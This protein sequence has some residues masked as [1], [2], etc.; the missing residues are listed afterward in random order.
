[1]PDADQHARERAITALLG[2]IALCDLAIPIDNHAR[3]EWVLA[4]LHLRAA[5]AAQTLF[6]SSIDGYVDGHPPAKPTARATHR[7]RCA[8]ALVR[9][10]ALHLSDVAPVAAAL[11]EVWGE[12]DPAT[13]QLRAIVARAAIG[14]PVTE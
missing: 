11:A 13:A 6:A 5:H 1:M 3:P 8:V 7:S 9:V 2:P 12:S 4:L 14:Q 10:A